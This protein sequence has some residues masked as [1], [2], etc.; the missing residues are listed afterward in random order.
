[1]HG[2]QAH[3]DDAR[4][5][6]DFVAYD[7]FAV[8][9]PGTGAAVLEQRLHVRTAAEIERRVVAAGSFELR[10]ATDEARAWHLPCRHR[11]REVVGD[12]G[13][14][15]EIAQ[16]G[17]ALLLQGLG[18]G[19]AGES[20]WHGPADIARHEIADGVLGV[21]VHFYRDM[22]MHVDE[23]RHYPGLLQV[24]HGIAGDIAVFDGR[25]LPALN[26]YRLPFTHRLGR[27]RDDMTDVEDGYG[28][29]GRGGWCSGCCVGSVCCKEEGQK[30]DEC[31]TRHG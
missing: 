12:I 3:L 9:S 6:T 30:R 22:R 17:E 21:Q 11:L 14:V 15:S 19:G 10:F 18:A 13:G 4:A 31:G 24:H 5:A 8:G 28:S 1:M 26:E 20:A 25:D 7:T 16:R 2:A 29:E 23:P 27:V